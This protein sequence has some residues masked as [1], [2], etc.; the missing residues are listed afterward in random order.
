MRTGQLSFSLK[1][2]ETHLVCMICGEEGAWVP[3]DRTLP[4]TYE[5][6]GETKNVVAYG[7]RHEECTEEGE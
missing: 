1:T 6:Q 3:Y 7:F 5:W 2:H 4:R